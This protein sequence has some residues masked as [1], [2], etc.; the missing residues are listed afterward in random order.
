MNLWLKTLMRMSWAK[1][2]ILI[3]LCWFGL[4]ALLTI[5]A[6]LVTVG[7]NVIK[8]IGARTTRS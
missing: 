5:G 2:L 7:R 4:L 3:F 8:A 6:A 1:I